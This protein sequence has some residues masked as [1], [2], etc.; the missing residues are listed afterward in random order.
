MISPC[1]TTALVNFNKNDTPLAVIYLLFSDDVLT[2]ARALQ[3]VTSDDRNRKS[4][5]FWL[6]IS[7]RYR[8]YTRHNKEEATIATSISCRLYLTLSFK[9]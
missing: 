6:V 9:Y 4:C 5:S 2:G 7:L 1:I 3:P 8:P